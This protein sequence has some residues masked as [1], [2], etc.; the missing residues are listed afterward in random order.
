MFK[1]LIFIFLCVNHKLWVQTSFISVLTFHNLLLWVKWYHLHGANAIFSLKSCMGKLLSCPPSSPYSGTI[2]EIFSIFFNHT[3]LPWHYE[4]WFHLD[5]VL[6]IDSNQ[7]SVKKTTPDILILKAHHM[8]RWVVGSVP[9]GE[10]TD[11]FLI[12][13][14]APWQV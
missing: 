2:I 5:V 6:N 1:I 10:A 3:L 8:V 9:Y 13:V 4:S 12:P 14:S 11:L 7:C